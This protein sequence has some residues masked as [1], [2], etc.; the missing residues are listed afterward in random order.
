MVSQ[1]FHDSAVEQPPELKCIK[2]LME[3][4]GAAN[5]LLSIFYFLFRMD[6]LLSPSL[7]RDKSFTTSSRCDQRTSS[8]ES[9]VSDGVVSIRRFRVTEID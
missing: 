6:C 4:T 8:I 5:L 7:L 2:L 9:A 3:V 1:V